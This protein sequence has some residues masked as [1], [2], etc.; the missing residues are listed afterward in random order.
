MVE[1]SKTKIE[2]SLFCFWGKTSE[3]GIHPA[4]CHMLDVGLVA[5]ELFAVQS[6]EF[7]QNFSK[8]FSD[9]HSDLSNL[10]GFFAALHDIGKISPGFQS[11][12]KDLCRPLESLGY[13]F[14]KHTETQHGAVALCELQKILQ[15]DFACSDETSLALSRTLAA[16]HGV[17][18]SVDVELIDS[19]SD[20]WCAARAK[21]VEFLARSFGVKDLSALRTSALPPLFFLAGLI[22]VADWLGS[23]EERF[24]YLNGGQQDLS[25]YIEDRTC[26][27]KRAVS[28]LR[29]A[30]RQSAEK[31]FAEL[32]PFHPNSCQKAMMKIVDSLEH[33]MLVIIESPMGSGKTE[34]AQAGYA[35][36]AH[37]DGLLGM[38]YALPTQATGNAMLPRME[39]FLKRLGAEG[40]AELHLLHANADMNR[41]YERLK[42]AG[43]EGGKDDVS[44][45]AWFA[46]RKRGLLASYGV[47]TLDQALVAA[48]KVRHFF[49]R[50]FGLSGKLLVMDEVHAYDAFMGEEIDR[51]IGWLSYMQTSVFL[52][53]ATLPREKKARL[54]RAFHPGGCVPATEYPCV[55]GIDR[56]GLI[57]IEPITGLKKSYIELLPVISMA[58]EKIGRAIELLVERVLG[59]GC[60]ACIMNTVG[61]AQSV[62]AGLKAKLDD[63]EIILFHSRFTLERRIEIEA[64]VLSRYGKGGNRPSRSVVIATQVIEQSLDVDFDF[65]VTD[66]APVDL[67]LQR[68]GRV[69]R[70]D[71]S[72]PVG[73]KDRRIYVLMPDFYSA[74]PE[75]GKSGFVYEKAI[76]FKTALLFAN[77]GG[78]RPVNAA[79]PYGVSGLIERVYGEG[80]ESVLPVHLVAAMDKWQEKH[81][82][83]ECA[84]TFAAAAQSL[85][86]AETYLNDLDYL[87][88]LANDFDDEK[89]VVTRLTRPSITLIVFD[90]D[91]DIAF[92]DS[93]EE[94]AI[95]SRSIS[96]DDRRAYDYFSK[97]EPPKEWERSPLLRYC[98]PLRLSDGRFDAEDFSISY[99]GEFGLKINRR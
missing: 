52:L 2:S 37:R 58:E 57:K 70:H 12:R 46:A 80:A 26:R 76:L 62:Y 77:D 6:E 1:K 69:H 33:P 79:I 13:E 84:E 43:V 50:L 93:E 4:L 45:S 32:F 89:V 55:A 71:R 30:S 22:S 63:T 74:A 96:T 95:Y 11:K 83:N 67:L 54:I 75:F 47:G 36:I 24:P 98:R 87:G 88:M 90:H 68:A 35:I 66:L 16:H 9:N 91:E 31:E 99:D 92:K 3:N 60:A 97:E 78:Y 72:R 41:D 29:F 5:K 81:E 51:L 59:G 18:L 38:Y 21:A 8:H 10:I 15:N 56:R 85:G 65:M 28:E 48:L 7:K 94:R 73:L 23:A 64:E 49:V 53:S 14:P 25:A 17:F 61:E 20:N 27:A 40:G 86:K 42:I 44:A 39:S 82:G 34:A 19:G